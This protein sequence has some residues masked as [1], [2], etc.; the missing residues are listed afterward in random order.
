MSGSTTTAQAGSTTTA[1]DAGANT[2]QGAGGSQAG[3]SQAAAGSRTF[4]QEEVNSL[5]AKERRETEA[6][7]SDYE[8]LKAKAARL[9]E[10]EEAGKTE[11][12]RAQA[13]AARYKK[14]ADELKAAAE[15]A[16]QVAEAAAELGVDAALLSRMEGDVRD[17]AELLAERFAAAGKYPSVPDRGGAGGR[18][19]GAPKTKGE[20]AAMGDRKERHAALVEMYTRK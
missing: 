11:L 18:G 14:E 3:G 4:T 15:R 8:D 12:E 17:N 2:A 16:A 7:F 6:R 19:A 10:I 20:I 9:D 1:D 13:E 5:V